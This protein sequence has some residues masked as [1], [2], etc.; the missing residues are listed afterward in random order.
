MIRQK[1]ILDSIKDDF[2]VQNKIIERITG[3]SSASLAQGLER[4]MARKI[5]WIIELEI[6]IVNC[7]DPRMCRIYDDM[8][9]DAKTRYKKQ[10]KKL[11]TLD[12][13]KDWDAI[14]ETDIRIN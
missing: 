13:Y 1:Q 3:V 7:D 8:I 4:D 10:F 9:L 2:L 11:K 14:T 6:K 12:N 5:E